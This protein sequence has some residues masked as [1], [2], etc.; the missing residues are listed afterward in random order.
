MPKNYEDPEDDPNMQQW[1]PVVLKKEPIFTKD[2]V[3]I[4]TDQFIHKLIEKRE[5]L[6]LSQ[7]QLN[8]KCKFSYKYTIRDI[9]SRRTLPTNMEIRT[10]SLILNI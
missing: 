5:E 6:K 10:I 3:E 4:T 1:S 2:K 9:E 8:T 7:I